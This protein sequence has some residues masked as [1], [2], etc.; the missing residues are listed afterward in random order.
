MAC[1]VPENI[2]SRS[3]ITAD[4]RVRALVKNTEVKSSQLDQEIPREDLHIIAGCF[5]NYNVYLD[6]LG[7][8]PGQCADIAKT[9]LVEKCNQSAMREALRCWIKTDPSVATFRTLLEIVF[10]LGR[11]DVAHLL[12]KYIV[13][14]IPCVS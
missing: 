13:E 11:H 2:T 1:L 14:T 12:C 3:L 8:D 9:E 7:L 10:S 6:K 5:D 4:Q